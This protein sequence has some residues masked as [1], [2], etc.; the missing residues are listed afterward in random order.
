MTYYD[1]IYDEAVDSNGL[2]TTA[3]ARTMGISKDDLTKM[4][5]RGKLYHV[6]HGVY[7]LTHYVPTVLDKYAEAVAIVGDGA[8][9]YGESV[10]AMFDLALVNPRKVTIATPARVR[11]KLPPYIKIVPAKGDIEVMQYEGVPSQSVADAFRT[12]KTTVMTERLLPAVEDARLKGLV[13]E[14][15]VKAL[16]REINSARKKT[17]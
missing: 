8:F 4:A 3:R 1:E 14:S 16:M 11:K 9:I 5:R 17:K 15:E 6:G 10:L 2:I 12:C 7:R 13:T